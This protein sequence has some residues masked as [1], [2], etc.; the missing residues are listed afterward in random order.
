M[1]NIY[2]KID[3]QNYLGAMGFAQAAH[4]KQK[5]KYTGEPY[6]YH[7]REVAD[8]IINFTCDYE[9]AAAAILHDILE[10]TFITQEELNRYFGDDITKM[11]V[12]VTDISK[13]EDGN[14]K[15]RKAIDLEHLR[16]CSDNAANIKYAD[17]ISNTKSIVKYDLN[18][19]MVY[20]PEKRKAMQALSGKGDR[21]LREHTYKVLQ[22]AELELKKHRLD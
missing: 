9:T 16:N 10:D 4:I 14:R 8:I 12:E 7:C 6:F 15:A 13:P 21:V 11:V 1:N 20:L 18:F 17:L 3:R 2:K 19:A 5:R 22:K